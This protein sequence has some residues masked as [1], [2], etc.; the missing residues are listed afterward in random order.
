MSKVTGVGLGMV[1]SIKH[2]IVL[3]KVFNIVVRCVVGTA[4]ATAYHFIRDNGTVFVV[5]RVFGQLVSS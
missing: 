2:G 5:A 3:I 4:T 1:L